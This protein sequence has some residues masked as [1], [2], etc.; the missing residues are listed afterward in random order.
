MSM[1]RFMKVYPSLGNA[2][3]QMTAA[4]VDGEPVSWSLAYREISQNT[5]F[6]NRIQNALEG[7][8]LI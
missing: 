8:G 3:R 2:E 6:G 1:D 5:A 4:V 7:M